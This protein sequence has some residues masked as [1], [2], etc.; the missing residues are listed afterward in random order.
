[1]FWPGD[2]IGAVVKAWTWVVGAERAG[3]CFGADGG[4]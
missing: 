1:M 3:G 2:R 4:L